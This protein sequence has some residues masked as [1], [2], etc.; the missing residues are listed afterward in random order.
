[1][2]ERE[3][4]E[5]SDATDDSVEIPVTVEGEEE[6]DADEEPDAAEADE[7]AAQ[8][9]A[10]PGE[11]VE[12]DVDE[13]EAA[14]PEEL[15]DLYL[16]PEESDVEVVEDEHAA[17][18]AEPVDAELVEDEAEEAEDVDVE[19]AEES[20]QTREPEGDEP[21]GPT[22]EEL[23]ARVE[24]LE[25]E[26][27]QLE[28]E[29]D[30]LERERDNFEE[31]MLRAAADLENFRKRSEREKEE[32]RKYGAKDLVK[33]LLETI[34][35]L[36]RALEHSDSGEEENIIEGVEMV[37][38]Q[39]HNT[40]GNHGIEAFESEGEEFDPEYHEAI[41]QV[42]TTDHESGTILEQHQKGYTIHDRLLRPA[43]VSVAKNV[44]SD[45]ETSDAE[46][47]DE[48]EAVEEGRPASDIEDQESGAGDAEETS[49]GADEE[50]TRDDG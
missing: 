40:L 31:R 39:I 6:S 48:A 20:T 43:V 22:R 15:D 13:A 16:D 35:N 24:E 17:E 26:V 7:R 1:M 19:L 45:D 33:D 44:A 18:E 10:D 47:A 30:Q 8:E 11:E 23:A 28:E 36:E 42:E 41:Q 37:L 38:R 25:T 34:D 2:T 49:G 9:A 21:E 29:T 46:D 3:E 12:A 5:D 14:D 27:D 32:I 4:R 50:E